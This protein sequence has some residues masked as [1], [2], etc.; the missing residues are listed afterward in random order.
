MHSGSSSADYPDSVINKIIMWFYIIQSWITAFERMLHSYSDWKYLCVTYC[1][2]YQ[3]TSHCDFYPF[4]TAKTTG[5]SKE[6]GR[7]LGFV[8]HWQSGRQALLM[9]WSNRRGQYLLLSPAVSESERGSALMLLRPRE[10]TVAVSVVVR[11]LLWG[12]RVSGSSLVR[13][14][15]R[16]GDEAVTWS[17][18]VL[19]SE[20]PW[21]CTGCPPDSV[22]A[23]QR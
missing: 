21:H 18:A 10:L 19:F 13:I 11:H 2:P 8:S 20:K 1:T 17:L 23:T 6:T 15:W 16:L 5:C 12:P 22:V 7:T 4:L 14:G 3:R 9:G